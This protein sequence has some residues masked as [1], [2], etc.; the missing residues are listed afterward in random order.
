[1]LYKKIGGL[2]A[3]VLIAASVLSCQQPANNQARPETSTPTVDDGRAVD[4]Q[5]TDTTGTKA[6]STQHNH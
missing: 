4:S 6:D 3:I 2:T 1:M 5:V